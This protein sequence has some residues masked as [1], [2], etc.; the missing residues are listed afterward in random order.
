MWSEIID[1]SATSPFL[2]NTHVIKATILDADNQ[3]INDEI[4]IENTTSH[5]A[6]N[7]DFTELTNG[8]IAMI[9]NH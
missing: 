1:G 3:I 4:I 5:T 8:N 7:L 2:D 9:Y 6:K